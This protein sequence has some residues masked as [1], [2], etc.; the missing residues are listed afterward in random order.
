[1]VWFCRFLSMLEE[2]VYGTSSP[3]WDPEFAQN[4]V[5]VTIPTST[6]T[7]NGTGQSIIQ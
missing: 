1:M 2:E 4:P 5:T 6:A 7:T 3:I